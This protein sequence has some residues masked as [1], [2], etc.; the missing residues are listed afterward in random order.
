MYLCSFETFREVLD[1][2]MKKSHTTLWSKRLLGNKN[3]QCL[4]YTL[5]YYIGKVFGIRPCEH[6]QLRV[7]NFFVEDDKITYH[8]NMS[9]TYHG[10]LNDLKKKG[11]VVTHY[12][13]TENESEHKN[14]VLLVCLNS[15]SIWFVILKELRMHFIFGRVKL[16][17]NMRMHR[18]VFTS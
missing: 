9:K 18:S 13:H 4:L 17:T 8:E 3:A 11:R 1:A 12:C 5:Y 14:H 16:I 6:R 2:E 15:I 10:E 7:S